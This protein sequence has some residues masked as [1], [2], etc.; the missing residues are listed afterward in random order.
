[1]GV[2]SI[3]CNTFVGRISYLEELEQRYC[4]TS[5]FFP[6]KEEPIYNKIQQ[7]LSD[8]NLESKYQTYKK[9]ML[10]DKI[11]LNQWMIKLFENSLT[12]VQ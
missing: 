11:D 3:R 4:L 6:Y 7:L 1:M 10:H 12:K 5:G 9:K 2:P 8:K